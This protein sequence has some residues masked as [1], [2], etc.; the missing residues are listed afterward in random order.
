MTQR[1]GRQ[2]D[3]LS[4]LVRSIGTLYQVSIA[5]WDDAEM[6]HTNGA[7]RNFIYSL[8]VHAAVYIKDAK[9]NFV[10][11]TLGSTKSHKK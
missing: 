1:S 4:Y 6:K 11:C 8:A 2:Q 5:I 7:T 3:L 9:R 10:F